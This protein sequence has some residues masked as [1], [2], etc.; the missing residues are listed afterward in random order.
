MG[1]LANVAPVVTC[2]WLAVMSCVVLA[3]FCATAEKNDSKPTL[4]VDFFCG[5]VWITLKKIINILNT[6]QLH[7]QVEKQ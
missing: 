4:G 5:V 1:N 2:K 7:D 6:P 3:R